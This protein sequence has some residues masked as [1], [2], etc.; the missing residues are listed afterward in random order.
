M[1]IKISDSKFL[2]IVGLGGCTLWRAF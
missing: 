2:V 1:S